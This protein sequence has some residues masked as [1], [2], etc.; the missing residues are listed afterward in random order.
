MGVI[1]D[2]SNERYHSMSGIGSSTVKTVYKKSLAHWKGQKYKSSTAFN[3]GKAVNDL[4]LEEDKDLVVK[5]PKTKTS[6]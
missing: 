2:M 6:K 5:G 1:K 4:L 3:L